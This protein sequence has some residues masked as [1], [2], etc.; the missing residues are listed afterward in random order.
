MPRVFLLMKSRSSST[1]YLTAAPSLTHF[2]PS[3]R[4]R[5]LFNVPTVVPSISAACLVE[6]SF[7]I[8]SLPSLALALPVDSGLISAPAVAAS[9]WRMPHSALGAPV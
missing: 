8:A 2:G 6:I 5:Q 1:S 3:P 4:E 7:G 9:T